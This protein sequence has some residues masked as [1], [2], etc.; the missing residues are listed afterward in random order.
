MLAAG[1][2]RRIHWP[3]PLVFT[4][5][6]Y[7]SP[8]VPFI[9]LVRCHPA[10]AQA[11]SAGAGI[12]RQSGIRTNI[13]NA[14]MDFFFR[15]AN[16]CNPHGHGFCGRGGVQAVPNTRWTGFSGCQRQAD[17]FQVAHLAKQA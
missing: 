3:R 12:Q 11:L 16:T 17:V 10:A 1:L 5:Q 13:E 4:N 6:G 15:G 9:D 14:T 2:N 8:D 7:E